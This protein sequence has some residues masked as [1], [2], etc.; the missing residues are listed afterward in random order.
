VSLETNWRHGFHSYDFAYDSASDFTA[1]DRALSSSADMELSVPLQVL[2]NGVSVFSVTSG[3]RRDLDVVDAAAGQGDYAEDFR[4]SFATIYGQRYLFGQLPFVE[5]YSAD[6]E[7]LFL[8]ESNGLS[9]AY[10]SAE[11]YLRF[12]RRFSSRIR[13]LFLP[14]FL[15]LRAAKQFVKEEELTD[16][17]NTYTLTARSTALN[18][19]GYF[20]AYPL[21]SFYRTDEF[22]SSLSLIADVDEPAAG[23][24]LRGLEMS[25][26]HF[27][28]FEGR[29]EE[30]LTI[31]NRLILRQD[32]QEIG[33]EILWED[34]AKIHYQWSRYPQSGLSLPLIPEEVEREGYWFHKESLELQLNGPGEQS[35]YYPLDI[36][37]SHK[38]TAMLPEYGEI[39]A[40]ISTGLDIERTSA[41]VMYT[42][43]GLRGGINVQIEF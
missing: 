37:L 2:D 16:L 23:P 21:F 33:P 22:S 38:S 39:S 17:Y 42:R 18:L 28:S 13:D 35:S 31:E 4:R 25:L 15:E 5:L 11:A 32:R 34:S 40:E 9:E 19:F 29:R 8:T 20:G 43:F 14:S 36:M 24:P 30:Q 7:G 3:Y 27:L 10:Y 26:D 12:S 41:G 6:A 1:A